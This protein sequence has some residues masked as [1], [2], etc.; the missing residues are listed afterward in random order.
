MTDQVHPPNVGG[1]TLCQIPAVK[2]LEASGEVLLSCRVRSEQDIPWTSPSA[3][4][5]SNGMP[6]LSPHMG[7]GLP[8][9]SSP[10]S[11]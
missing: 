3:A 2:G 6:P 5:P 11:K 8:R 10:F 1:S 7:G 4:A 9:Q